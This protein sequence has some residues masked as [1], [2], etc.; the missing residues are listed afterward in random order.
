MKTGEKK[1]Q[2]TKEI[3]HTQDLIVA[4]NGCM[5]YNF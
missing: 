2:T 5:A 4:S 1:Y 3:S